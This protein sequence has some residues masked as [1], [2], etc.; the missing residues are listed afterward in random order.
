MP[1]GINSIVA[2]ELQQKGSDEGMEL[3][4]Y[5][6]DIVDTRHKRMIAAMSRRS[7][8]TTSVV[9]RATNRSMGRVLII[10]PEAFDV[11]A[12]VRRFEQIDGV[13]I[14]STILYAYIKL[15]KIDIEIVTYRELPHMK[16]YY[17]ASF[18]DVILYEPGYV[19]NDS[20]VIKAMQ[21]ANRLTKIGGKVLMIG[22]PPKDEGT[23]FQMVWD[24]ADTLGYKRV[25]VP[26]YEVPWLDPVKLLG[27]YEPNAIDNELLAQFQKQELTAQHA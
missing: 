22:T 14:Y 5:Q 24:Y 15:D 17:G 12:L 23:C 1:C 9:L 27:E 4:W 11:K 8:K 2:P 21:I 3:T 16:R 10:V 13:K 6:K 18:H 25:H 19:S 7:G 26:I 20:L